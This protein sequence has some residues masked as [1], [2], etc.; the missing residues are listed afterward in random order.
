MNKAI[1][2][3][4]VYPNPFKEIRAYCKFSCLQKIKLK[5]SKTFIRF[6]S[7][8][9]TLIRIHVVWLRKNSLIKIIFYIIWFYE[10]RIYCN[11]NVK[12]ANKLKKTLE[13]S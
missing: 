1:S 3:I 12:V 7:P 4:N 9:H 2:S 8:R 11:S 6:M 13:K 5:L 10:N